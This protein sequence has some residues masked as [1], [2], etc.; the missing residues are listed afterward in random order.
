MWGGRRRR[1]RDQPAASSTLLLCTAV[2]WTVFVVSPC[3]QRG[4]HAAVSAE[5]KGIPAPHQPTAAPLLQALSRDVRSVTQRVKVPRRA[6]QGQAGLT[7]QGGVQRSHPGLVPQ[8]AGGGA[9]S[10]GGA[11]ASASSLGS[12]C[13]SDSGEEGTWH[14]VLDGIDISYEIEE[15]EGEAEG[16]IVLLRTAALL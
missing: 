1:E 9:G 5:A 15:G 2:H 14:V 16:S 11:A 3:V 8:L 7:L 6:A 13:N 12:I 4:H 10:S